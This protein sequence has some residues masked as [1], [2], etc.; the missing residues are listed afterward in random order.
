MTDYIDRASFKSAMADAGVHGGDVTAEEWLN[1][2]EGYAT[3]RMNTLRGFVSGVADL[4]T[5]LRAKLRGHKA[6]EAAAKADLINLEA[7]RDKAR[8]LGAGDMVRR[9][10][11]RIGSAEHRA[12]WAAYDSRATRLAADSLG[13]DLNEKGTPQ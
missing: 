10:S 2:W 5:A 8:D 3:R 11:R 12:E 7:L 4:V 6:A 13:I 9:I 1:V